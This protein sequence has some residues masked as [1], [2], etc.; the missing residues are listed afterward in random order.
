VFLVLG[1]GCCLVA[2]STLLFPTVGPM[3][4]RMGGGL[5][6]ALSLYFRFQLLARLI[7]P[8]FT[9]IAMWKGSGVIR[10]LGALVLLVQLPITLGAVLWLLGN[11]G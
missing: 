7:G 1:A 8:V 9:G 2:W 11:I 4:A 10:L 3:I 6:V 5:H